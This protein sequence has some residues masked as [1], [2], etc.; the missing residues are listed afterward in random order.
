MKIDFLIFGAPNTFDS[1]STAGREY[2]DFAIDNF[3]RTHD[4]DARL[5]IRR[6]GQ[7]KIAYTYVRSRKISTVIERPKSSFGMSLIFKDRYITDIKSIYQLFDQIYK[8][9]VMG[10]ILEKLPQSDITKYK[11]NEFSIADPS[12][13][14]IMHN[15]FTNIDTHFKDDFAPLSE[16][17][18]NLGK[19]TVRLS[20]TMRGNDDFISALKQG[21][22][23]S[24]SPE[25][26]IPREKTSKNTSANETPP[27][28]QPAVCPAED[29]TKKESFNTAQNNT[30]S[31]PA[32]VD[33]PPPPKKLTAGDRIRRWAYYNLGLDL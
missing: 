5:D 29:G 4:A 6:I 18:S 13:K 22:N 21:R 14:L 15:F 3:D 1:A 2:S 23:I 24:I 17:E 32:N 16:L 7:D 9:V 20:S 10:R 26:E 33:T 12:V 19:G 8:K 25:Y 28:P 30:A 27:S 31:L 11:I